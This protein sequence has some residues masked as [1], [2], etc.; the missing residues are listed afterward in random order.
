MEVGKLPHFLPIDTIAMEKIFPFLNL[1]DEHSC[2]FSY[3]GILMWVDMFDYEYA[4]YNDTLFIKGNVP[5]EGEKTVHRPA[6]SMPLG[7][8]PLNE[9]VEMLKEWCKHED[10]DLEFSSVTPQASEMLMSLGAKEKIELPSWED[11]IYDASSLATLAGKKL[12]KKRNHVNQFKNIYKDW[13]FHI[14]QTTDVDNIRGE[15]NKA[16]EKEASQSKEARNE[17][18]FSDRLLEEIKIGNDHLHGGVLTVNNEIVAYTIGDI[19]GD[20]LYIHVEK[21]ER[22]IAGSFEMINKCFAEAMLCHHPGLKFI[23]REDDA[24]DPGLQHA[25]NSYHPLYILKKYNI[26]F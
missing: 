25:K 17:R 23:N 10:V 19:I 22:S 21:A 18:I 11:Y 8:M 7:K 6:F 16:I 14:M 1:H 4:I 15:I 12:S 26:K 2:D 3:G 9:A 5:I 20:T 24:G 13:K